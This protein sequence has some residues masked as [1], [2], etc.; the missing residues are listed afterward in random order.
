MSTT[1]TFKDQIDLP[2]WR[3]LSPAIT[4]SAAAVCM[5]SDLRN[6]LSR[7]PY[8]WKWTTTTTI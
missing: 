3:P 5:T 6:D 4:A 2:E 1:F 7:D 8:V